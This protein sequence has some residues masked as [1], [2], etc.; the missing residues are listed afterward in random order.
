[1][2]DVTI[3]KVSNRREMKAFVRFN[4]ELYKDCPY[5]VPDLLED[6]LDTFNP[7]K[8]AAFDFCEADC[9]LALREGKI[10]GRIAAIINHKANRTWGTNNARFGWIDFVDDEEV[11]R[12]LLEAAE[13]WGRD[14]GCDKLTGP[15]GFTDMDPEGML[16][17]GYDQLSTM[18]TTYNYPYYPKHMERLGYAKEVDWVERKILTPEKDRP[19]HMDK[20]FRVAE[21]SAKRYNLH[22]RKFKNA[23]EIR[24]GGWAQKIFD[25]VNKAYAPLYGYSE[26]TPKQ[27]EQ[28]VREYMPFLDMRLVTT[29]EDTDG[30]I[31]AMGVGMPSLSRAIQKAHARLFPFGWIHLAKALYFKHADIVDLLLVAVLPEYQNKGVNAMLFA[32]LIPVCQQMGF[33]F[34]E[35][36]P[37]LETNEKSQGQWAYLDAEIHKRRRCWQ[38]PL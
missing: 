24:Q 36:H 21:M 23:S 30:R 14:H 13:K 33:K 1:M 15:L 25:V 28:Y 22:I 4:Y 5:A 11:S 17:G 12:A 3:K 9:F 16:T 19:A 31:V 34:G 38:K 37:Q 32:D 29:V 6:T 7:R 26:M 35:T 27:I 2:S 20:Y 8:N 10:V 18:S